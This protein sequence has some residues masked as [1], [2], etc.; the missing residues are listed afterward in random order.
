MDYNIEVK[1]VPPLPVLTHIG[2]VPATELE[3]VAY[4]LHH[5]A[6]ANRTDS[7]FCLS[8]YA[9]L[10]EDTEVKI[11]CPI[12]SVDLDISGSQ[13]KIEVLPRCLVLTTIHTGVYNELKDV[14]K[15]MNEYIIKNKLTT[16]LPYRMIYHPE[17]REK[18]RPHLHK[19]HE[20]EYVTE[21]QIPILDQ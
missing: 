15:V 4:G 5:K 11:C 10:D 17:K 1:N 14:F 18:Q 16:S 3:N 20:N 21:I 2:T 19:R 7:L 8:R 6:E 12:H 13:Y 9:T